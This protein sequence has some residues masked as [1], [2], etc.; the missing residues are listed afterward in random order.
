VAE[1]GLVVRSALVA[2]ALLAA[3]TSSNPVVAPP[4][5]QSASASAS[6]TPSPS[7]VPSTP[8]PSVTRSGAPVYEFGGGQASLEIRGNVPFAGSWLLDHGFSAPPSGGE[9]D[10]TYGWTDAG[11]DDRLV[12]NV[13]SRAPWTVSGKLDGSQMSF[14]QCTVKT[15][16]NDPGG[17]VGSFTCAR[18]TRQ[19]TVSPAGTAT[20]TF[21]QEP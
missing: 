4:P 10:G 14:Q 7:A 19:G 6:P 5:S 9:A 15:E 20:A 17:L 13:P 1:A 2:L 11:G 18:V 12:L 16:R 21:S 3:C 8:S